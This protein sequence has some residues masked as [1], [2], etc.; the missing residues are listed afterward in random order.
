[1]ERLLQLGLG[2]LKEYDWVK[3]FTENGANRLS[4]DFS[5]E[6][7]LSEAEKHLIFP[8]ISR[9]QKGEASDGRYLLNC[10]KTYTAQNGDKNY[11]EAMHWFVQ[12]ENWHSVYL[13]KFMDYYHVKVCKKSLLDDCFR[14]LRKL[15]GL[16][17]EI[18]V[19]VTAEMIALVYYSALA[20]CTGSPALKSICRQ[21]LHDELRHVAFQSAT[22]HKMKIGRLGNLLRILIMEITMSVVWLSMKDVFYVG[23]YSFSKYAAE[24]LGYLHQSIMISKKG[25]L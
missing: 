21:M 20:E 4:I 3:Y 8:S 22:L 16:K 15:C 7:G 17:S 10:V 24:C 19:L 1:M 2:D 23:G 5:Q 14:R 11:R 25:K 13:K 6:T 12:E 18:V 9:F